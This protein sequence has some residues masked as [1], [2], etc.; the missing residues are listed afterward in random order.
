MN[1]VATLFQR[2]LAGL[3]MLVLSAGTHADQLQSIQVEG[4]GE[5]GIPVAI[6]V[7]IDVSNASSANKSC[8][9][10]IQYGDGVVEEF[11]PGRNGPQ[12]FPVRV[13]HLYTA[14]G[15]YVIKAVGKTKFRGFATAIGCTGA[16]LYA[17]HAVS[18]G[19]ARK[20]QES[21]AAKADELDAKEAN[22]RKMQD[23]LAKAKQVQLQREQEL[24]L[25]EKRA[26]QAAATA[27]ASATAAAKESAL[28]S[29]VEQPVTPSKKAPAKP[30][31]TIDAF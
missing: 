13:T 12:E 14:P 3:A 2:S 24:D 16:D 27:A 19:A 22:L 7:N 15:N 4:Q 20:A 21:A 8:G 1:Q 10:D 31:A 11:L 6:T 28:K 5:I 29:M 23:E 25:K 26:R 9:L 30:S 17:P 18:D